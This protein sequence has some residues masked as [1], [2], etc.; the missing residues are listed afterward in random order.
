MSSMW[1]PYVESLLSNKSKSC[2]Q[3]K[4]KLLIKNQQFYYVTE[5][6][7]ICENTCTSM[8]LHNKPLHYQYFHVNDMVIQLIMPESSKYKTPLLFPEQK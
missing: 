3:T 1:K 2:R 5:I 8:Y 4:D 7:I 6:Y